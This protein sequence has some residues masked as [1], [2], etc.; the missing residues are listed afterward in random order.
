MDNIL[1]MLG[2]AH[3]AGRVEIG[4][5]PV[6]G[7]ARA[8]KA[9]VIFVAEDAGASSQRRAF[10]FAQTGACLCLTIPA[11]K[12]ALGSALGRTS[13]AMC[14]VTDIGF[15]EALVKKLAAKDEKFVPAAEALAV[16]AKRAAARKREQAQ[17]EKN[18]RSGK[19]RAKK[20]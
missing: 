6:G 3:R 20:Q 2:L 13:V 12:D 11:E 16:K 19:K 17:H 15:A 9:R 5:E 18:V 10:S 1:S 8:K 4:E 7:A 14:A